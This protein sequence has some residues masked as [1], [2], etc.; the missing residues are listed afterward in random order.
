MIWSTQDTF[1]TLKHLIELDLGKNQLRE[2]PEAF[3]QLVLLQKLDL[4]SNQ[5][6]DLPLG[7]WQLKKLKWLDLKDNPRLEPGLAKVAGTCVDEK[8]CKECAKEVGESESERGREKDISRGGY[9]GGAWGA[10]APPSSQD[11]IQASMDIASSSHSPSSPKNL[12]LTY[13]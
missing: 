10:Q 3:G 6:V 9:R 1:C 5:L 7:F 8:E 13:I 2:L 12:D 11:N 4:Y